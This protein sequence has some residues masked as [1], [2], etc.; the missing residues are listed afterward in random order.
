MPIRVHS[1]LK[2]P[3]QQ[4]YSL[5][6]PKAIT[7]IALGVIALVVGILMVKGII[8]GGNYGYI[9]CGFGAINFIGLAIYYCCR[10]KKTETPFAISPGKQQTQKPKVIVT[11]EHKM[12]DHIK[13]GNVQAAVENMK[14]AFWFDH[15]WHVEKTLKAE[16]RGSFDQNARKTCMRVMIKACLAKDRKF[17][18]D[19]LVDEQTPNKNEVL[20][21]YLACLFESYQN[22]SISQGQLLRFFEEVWGLCTI[23][24]RIDGMIYHTCDERTFAKMLKPYLLKIIAEP[25][26]SFVQLDENN[27]R[28]LVYRLGAG[29]HLEQ[30]VEKELASVKNVESFANL[31]PIF[32]Y[33]DNHKKAD[34][35][36][37]I[38]DRF[39][40][41]NLS[42]IS[43]E[44]YLPPEEAKSYFFQKCLQASLDCLLT[45]L[46]QRFFGSGIPQNIENLL[47]ERLAQINDQDRLVFKTVD[48]IQQQVVQRDTFLINTGLS[49]AKEGQLDR[50]LTYFDKLHK[51]YVPQE[52]FYVTHNFKNNPFYQFAKIA[53]QN[54]NAAL[55]EKMFSYI[56]PSERR[57]MYRDLIH[58]VCNQ[59]DNPEN[60]LH[61]LLAALVFFESRKENPAPSRAACLQKVKS[62]DFTKDLIR[63]LLKV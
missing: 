22:K 44:Q 24:Q 15:Q 4:D 36:R 12:V 29:A 19:K 9:V 51:I 56:H 17:F 27:R 43:F 34:Y 59:L 7:L 25:D 61:N 40:L 30:I 21:D 48:L 2:T 53:L 41:F 10:D 1:H 18:L 46:P 54:N 26:F 37:K 63:Q 49:L 42:H 35:S 28:S 14:E 38:L 33:L 62:L 20:K 47:I 8:S 13:N 52:G 57:Q 50:A 39:S 60:L 55:C 16:L 23:S 58:F 45:V 3:Q 32:N 11:R 31:G 5:D 6:L